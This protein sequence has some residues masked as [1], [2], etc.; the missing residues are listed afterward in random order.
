MV[1]CLPLPGPASQSPGCRAWPP[2]GRSHPLAGC[3]MRWPAVHRWLPQP[4]PSP[5]T[6]VRP[7]LA[8]AGQRHP[9][10]EAT[11]VTSGGRC[12]SMCSAV[13]RGS[14]MRTHPKEDV[15]EA[16]LHEGVHLGGGVILRQQRPQHV[17]VSIFA[18]RRCRRPVVKVLRS[19]QVK[20]LSRAHDGVTAP[21]CNPPTAAPWRRRDRTW[22]PHCATQPAHAR[23]QLPAACAQRRSRPLPRSCCC[24]S[25]SC[26]AAGEGAR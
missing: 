14:P 25:R 19:V 24:G 26:D 18:S 6:A 11:T 13:Q 22:P 17:V 23:R 3:Q 4:P 9:P 5:S 20:A 21:R 10:A 15:G 1:P 16:L 2:A 7:C 8:A 12:S